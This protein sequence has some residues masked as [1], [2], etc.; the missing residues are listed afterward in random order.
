MKTRLASLHL[1]AGS[2]G[3]AA[4]IQPICQGDSGLE[5][6]VGVKAAVKEPTEGLISPTRAFSEGFRPTALCLGWKKK[7]GGDAGRI[8]MFAEWWG[9]GRGAVGRGQ[10]GAVIMPR[11]SIP[12]MGPGPW[13]GELYPTS[14]APPVRG[15][16]PSARRVTL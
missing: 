3:R 12:D 5:G 8:L 13:W 15:C 1:G 11:G 2:W 9:A 7:A 6:G 4:F 16:A 10:Q 14:G